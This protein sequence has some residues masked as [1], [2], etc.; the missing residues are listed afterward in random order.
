MST[1]LMVDHGHIIPLK[2]E[3]N[4]VLS[5]DYLP[6]SVHTPSCESSEVVDIHWVGLS[7]RRNRGL[8]KKSQFLW[9]YSYSEAIRHLNAIIVEQGVESP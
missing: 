3:K 9:G 4:G 5:V 8:F 7:L 6:R 1:I 2:F